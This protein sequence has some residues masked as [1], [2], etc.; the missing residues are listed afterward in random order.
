M[1]GK[2]LFLH[3]KTHSMI[4]S[5]ELKW[6]SGGL[7]EALGSRIRR[8]N[9][10]DY[11]CTPTGNKFVGMLNGMDMKPLPSL[12]NT[13]VGVVQDVALEKFLLNE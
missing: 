6:G 7:L 3:Q 5:K 9:Y 10:F 11:N 12:S 4:G 2:K 8:E 1:L 13:V